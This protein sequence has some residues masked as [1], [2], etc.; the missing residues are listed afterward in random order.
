MVYS[1]T[2]QIKF[3]NLTSKKPVLIKN[4]VSATA[5]TA[6]HHSV[7]WSENSGSIFS[8]SFDGEKHEKIINTGN[9]TYLITDFFGDIFK[10]LGFVDSHRNMI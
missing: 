7:F 1:T 5:L 2:N 9:Y 6:V 8:M 10:K 3:L 4:G